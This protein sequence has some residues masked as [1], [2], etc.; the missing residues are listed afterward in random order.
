MAE[1]I[2]DIVI[3][4]E[5]VI[6][7]RHGESP[8]NYWTVWRNGVSRHGQCSAEDVMRALASYAHQEPPSAITNSA[9][10]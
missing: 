5:E 7:L 2:V 4:G 9:K 10:T 3:K 6:V 1:V 8:N